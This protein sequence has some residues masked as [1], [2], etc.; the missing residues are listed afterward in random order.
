[1]KDLITQTCFARYIEARSE[2]IKTP[3]YL[4]NWLLQYINP[5]YHKIYILL[6]FFGLGHQCSSEHCF[7]Y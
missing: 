3:L 2:K 4:K 6:V 5:I 1:M 7:F